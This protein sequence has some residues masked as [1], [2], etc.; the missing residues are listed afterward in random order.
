MGSERGLFE[1]LIADREARIK[2]L[3]AD[4][5]AHRE[6]IAALRTKIA[7]FEAKLR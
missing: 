4:K 5:A 2:E 1:R 3:Q 6:E 7:E